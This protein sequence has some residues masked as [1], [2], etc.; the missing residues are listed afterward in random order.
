[1]RLRSVRTN[2]NTRLTE[3]ELDNSSITSPD[4]HTAAS[5]VFDSWLGHINES[6]TRQV[7][8]FHSQ[9]FRNRLAIVDLMRPLEFVVPDGRGRNAQSTVHRRCHVLRLEWTRCGIRS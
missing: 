8:C 1:M 4:L 6:R 5:G 7:R 3:F 9:Q 2:Q